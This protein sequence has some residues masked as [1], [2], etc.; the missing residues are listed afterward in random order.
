MSDL[1]PEKIVELRA[2]QGLAHSL[3]RLVEISPIG[4]LF[5]GLGEFFLEKVAQ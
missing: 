3:T 5:E 1:V 2:R 4:L